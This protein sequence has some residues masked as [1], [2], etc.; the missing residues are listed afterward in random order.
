MGRVGSGG[1]WSHLQGEVIPEVPP[2]AP[3]PEPMGSPASAGGRVP[4]QPQP[5][6][7]EQSSDPPIRDGQQDEGGQ[8]ELGWNR[9]GMIT[10]P[11][12]TRTRTNQLGRTQVLL[13]EPGSD[14]SGPSDLTN[15]VHSRTL[16]NHAGSV[17]P[18]HLL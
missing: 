10:G 15:P 11:G 16:Q 5:T 17:Q 8:A 12:R 6:S 13:T 14:G 3:P 18:N 4:V 2:H 1:F 7:I 9:D